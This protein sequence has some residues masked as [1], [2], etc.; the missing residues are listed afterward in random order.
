VDDVPSS[1][2]E[3]SSGDTAD[4]LTEP[5]DFASSPGGLDSEDE[6][7]NTPLLYV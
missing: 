7:E 2:T 1:G 3:S 6:V 5:V 4:G